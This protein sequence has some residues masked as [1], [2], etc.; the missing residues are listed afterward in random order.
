MDDANVKR[1]RI[2]HRYSKP[3][4]P[5]PTDDDRITML[6]EQIAVCRKE[7][8]DLIASREVP[9]SQNDL[10]CLFLFLEGE[11][12]V[13][14]H[15]R[16]IRVPVSLD[17]FCRI[18]PYHTISSLC[19]YACCPFVPLISSFFTFRT[20]RTNPPR[21]SRPLR[22]TSTSTSRLRSVPERTS[23]PRCSSMLRTL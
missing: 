5:M 2:E 12:W 18:L 15:T 8:A 6:A 10:L 19:A 20:S 17:P 11:T 13:A 14:R 3:R 23:K 21:S 16:Y 22:T 7:L 1:M 4:L 9:Y